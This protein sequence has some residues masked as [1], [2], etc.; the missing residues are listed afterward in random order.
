MPATI[1]RIPWSAM[2]PH[3]DRWQHLRIQAGL[4]HPFFSPSWFNAVH[5]IYQNVEVLAFQSPEGCDGFLPFQRQGWK[6]AVPAGGHFVDYQGVIGTPLPCL[7][8]TDILTAAG[9][10]ALD[11][12]HGVPSAAAWDITTWRR[13]SSPVIRL[14]PGYSNLIRFWRQRGSAWDTLARKERKLLREKGPWR[15]ISHQPR[16]ELLDLLM[17]WKRSQYRT[18]GVRDVLAQPTDRQLL[19]HLLRQ[20]REFPAWGV[21]LSVLECQNTPIALHL[22]LHENG[23][24][25]YWFPAYH[26]TWAAYSPGLILLR[27]MIR[28]ACDLNIEIFDFGKGAAR[29]KSEWANDSI[30]LVEGSLLKPGWVAARRILAQKFRHL[31]RKAGASRLKSGWNHLRSNLR[32]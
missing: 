22:G 16:S 28:E 10:E 14:N 6:T 3:H 15:F 30:P 25:H 31:A 29:Y 27:E 23:I 32:R 18:T 8:P 12:D 5:D 19:H 7:P 17:T 4:L 11:I 9:L 21:R 24:W 2:N 20:N 26:P 1:E 13:T